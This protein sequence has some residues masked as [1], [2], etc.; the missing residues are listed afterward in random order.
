MNIALKVGPEFSRHW[1]PK[2]EGEL[3]S[4]FRAFLEDGDSTSWYGPTV[5]SS[6]EYFSD[7]DKTVISY[8]AYN[9]KNGEEQE[10]RCCWYNHATGK[11]SASYFVAT[12]LI[13]NDKHSVP[14]IA[15]THQNH[16]IICGGSHSIVSNAMTVTMSTNPNDISAWTAQANISAPIGYPHL[17][18]V[19]NSIYLFT[20]NDTNEA[21]TIRYGEMLIGTPSNA[22]IVWGSILRFADL[23]ADS[24]YYGGDITIGSQVST[25]IEI[26][27]TRANFADTVRR[28]VYGFIFDTTDSSIKNLDKSVSVAAA[29]WQAGNVGIALATWNTSFRLFDHGSRFGAAPAQCIAN[30]QRHIIFQNGDN[31]DDELYYMVGNVGSISFSAP[32][33]VADVFQGG[34]SFAIV[35]GD[36]N[37]VEIWYRKTDNKLYRRRRTSGGTML[38]EEL[39]YYSSVQLD[40]PVAPRNAHA[41]LRI[42]FANSNDDETTEGNFNLYATGAL[43][44]RDRGIRGTVGAIFDAAGVAYPSAAIINAYSTFLDAAIACGRWPRL[45]AFWLLNPIAGAHLVNWKLDRWRLTEVGTGTGFDSGLLGFRSNGSDR[46]LQTGMSCSLFFTATDVQLGMA[47]GSGSGS[48]M[49]LGVVGGTNFG[50]CILSSTN[51]GDTASVGS[52][53]ASTSI[54]PANTQKNGV[55]DLFR[56]SNSCQIYREGASL[57]A[58]AAVTDS[59]AVDTNL[60]AGRAS[61]TPVFASANNPLYAFWAG[62]GIAAGAARDAETAAFAAALKTLLNTLVPGTMP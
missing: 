14:S 46:Y 44:I 43:G 7:I 35:P 55:F 62:D 57:G 53:N 45:R 1:G 26:L 24:R 4:V 51:A 28:G 8:Q 50:G 17:N 49:R 47:C 2:G 61:S 3:V 10:L 6:A 42:L 19:G 37:G 56:E 33:K 39:M 15:R 21:G 9:G 30:G 31:N 41:N 18:R 58:P 36:S 52:W 22:T 48:S 60:V 13:T 34:G 11:F 54:A 40:N 29:T 38:A 59:A 5:S 16:F 27:F 23:G 25:D 20:R 12:C 32:T